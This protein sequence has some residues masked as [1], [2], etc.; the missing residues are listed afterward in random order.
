MDAQAQDRAHRIGQTRDVHIYRLVTEHTIEE[1]IL[2]K[3]KQKRQL[4]FLVMDEGKFSMSHT[5]GKPKLNKN[6]DSEGN[7][8]NAVFTKEGLRDILGVKLGDDDSSIGTSINSTSIIEEVSSKDND[9]VLSKE[10][11]EHAMAVLEDEDDVKA[12]RGAQ[13]EAAEKLKEF[14]ETVQFHKDND[15]ENDSLSQYSQDD[16]TMDDEQGRQN[17]KDGNIKGQR[18]ESFKDKSV[19]QQISTP[20]TENNDSNVNDA[21]M[22]REFAAWQKKVG[23]DMKTISESLKPTER[24]GKLFKENI[25]PFYSVHYDEIEELRHED[26]NH[27]EELE[28]DIDEIEKHKET[29]ERQVI[30]D[31]DLLATN[32]SPEYL[33]HLRNVYLQEKVKLRNQKKRRKLTGE[34]WCTKIDGTTKLPFWYNEDT[35]EAIW[36]KPTVLLELEADR[37][38][39]ENKWISLPGKPLYNIMSFLLPYPDRINCSK[40]CRQWRTAATDISF[41]KH[42]FPVEMSGIEIEATKLNKI[43]FRTISDAI[44]TA[45]PGDTIE[46]GDGHYW[47]N[48]PGISVDFP[49]RIVGDEND[50]SHVVLEL[51]GSII[52]KGHAGWIEGVTIRRPKMA[53]EKSIGKEI[54]RVEGKGK[55]DMAFCVFD[56]EGG[57]G[58]VTK[59]SGQ[60]SK[61]KWHDILIKNASVGKSG[62]L[63][64]ENSTLLMDQVRA[65]CYISKAINYTVLLT[66]S[67]QHSCALFQ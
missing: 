63:I 35:G 24:Y 17:T 37:N 66:Y 58:N 38:A 16:D 13:K 20:G 45:V 5:H 8:G 44:A 67:Y 14:D 22:E 49:L 65:K 47:I 40:V 33:P 19:S 11:M 34:N 12:M 28:F 18:K 48:D 29:Q 4:D 39:H 61:G 52:W 53:S 51:R 57:T 41:V 7:K 31:G 2:L 25:D 62:L 46:L 60:G 54:L 36:E 50:P 59:L 26:E 56:N 3:A 42:V 21:Q 15:L 10:Q 64:D 1:N 43:Y 55:I 32:P 23:I 6:N 27:E 30:E 9:Q